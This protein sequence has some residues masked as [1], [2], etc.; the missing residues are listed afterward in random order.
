MST[1]SHPLTRFSNYFQLKK[2]H[3][4]LHKITL[5]LLVTKLTLLNRQSVQQSY[6]NTHTQRL[7]WLIAPAKIVTSNMMTAYITATGPH[8]EMQNA[9]RKN[10]LKYVKKLQEFK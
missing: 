2:N 7:T 8:V 3:L 9:G 4:E 1:F 6:T 10:M 5:A